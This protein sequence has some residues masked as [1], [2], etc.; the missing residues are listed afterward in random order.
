LDLIYDKI[1]K[2]LPL[3]TT[4]YH[5]VNKF[6]HF[7]NQIVREKPLL[8]S[9]KPKKTRIFRDEKFYTNTLRNV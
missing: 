5:F 3:F 4:K 7:N 6:L 9:R 8:E 2:I 1:K